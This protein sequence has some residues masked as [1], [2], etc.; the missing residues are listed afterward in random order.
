LIEMTSITGRLLP[1]SW[2]MRSAMG[3]ARIVSSGTK[4]S[5]APFFSL[6]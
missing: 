1:P 4:V 3:V 5:G 2:R 6:R